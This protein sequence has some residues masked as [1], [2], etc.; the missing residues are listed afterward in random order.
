MKLS[1]FF[2]L[3][4]SNAC[5]IFAQTPDNTRRNTNSF[6][7]QKK[8]STD[9]TPGTNEIC[10]NGIDDD[11]DYLTDMQDYSCYFGNWSPSNC[12][13]SKM[14]W[15]TCGTYLYWVDIA[16]NKDRIINFP[17]NEIYG[18]IT[19]APNGKL[20]GGE[21][22]N[23]HIREINPSTAQTQLIKT[24]AGYNSI[25]AMTADGFSNLYFCARLNTNGDLWHLLKYNLTSGQLTVLVDLTANNISTG[26]DLTF[27]NGYLYLSCNDTKI[28]KF[29]LINWSFQVL[30]FTGFPYIAAYG[31]TTFGDGYL[32]LT[33]GSEIYQLNLST[34]TASLYYRT[35]TTI[36]SYG[37]SGYS[38]TCEMPACNASVN[39]SIESTTP[40]C[41]S[42]G[43]QLKASGT[44]INGSTAYKWTLPDNS[45]T[46]GPLL[47]AFASGKYYVTY[48]MMTDSCSAIDSI[49][50]NLT[51]LPAITL[52]NDTA[53]CPALQVLL[54]PQHTQF[55]QSYLWQDGTTNPTYT[56]TQAGLYWVEATNI[57]GSKRDSVVVMQQIPPV[58]NL[59]NDTLLCFQT[60]IKLK[61]IAIKNQ[62]DKYSWSSGSFADTMVITQPGKYWLLS[63]NVCGTASDSVTVSLKDS[64]TCKPLYASVNL[65]ADGE[66]CPGDTINLINSNHNNSYRYF[67][68]DG[69]TANSYIVKQPGLYWLEAASYCNRQRDS[70]YIKPAVNCDCV[71]Y[72]P[73]A[74]S[75][76]NDRKNDRYKPVCFCD[77]KGEFFVYNRY[78]NLVYS[79][80]NLKEG[81]DGN[82]MNTQQ[83]GGGY[84]YYL[85]YSIKNQSS[86]QSKKGTFLLLR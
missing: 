53:I 26:G 9:F 67:W 84:T 33:G 37:L 56:A 32:Y 24:I 28:A 46:A 47:T 14:V 68:Q 52:G 83:P 16:T 51:P 13:P 5:S 77:I 85:I 60:S 39:I 19:W 43:V 8:T 22:F 63:Y 30:S 2:L 18:D 21:L 17:N 74:F 82:Y 23:A 66:I 7:S 34:L 73:S 55:I 12:I 64:C 29:D 70:V 54:Q 36:F 79:S 86:V 6:T 48:S 61:N 35:P 27:I 10:N 57:C 1:V 76:N 81:W 50:V 20:Y 31:T 3:L 42:T 59:G 62:Y 11:G 80:K 78:G 40:Y 72:L 71:V 41:T 58:V 45:T 75:P 38:E 49:T 4:I 25:N 15:F 65:G 69:S 44:G